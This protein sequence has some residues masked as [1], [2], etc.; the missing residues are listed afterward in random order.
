MRTL[1][2]VA[3][4]I[5]A[6]LGGATRGAAGEPDGIILDFSAKWC[7]PCQ[8]MLPCLSTNLEMWNGIETLGGRVNNPMFL[9]ITTIDKK[10]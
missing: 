5:A 6:T 3:V 7:P 1:T 10:L 2:S 8:Q 4:L 9:A